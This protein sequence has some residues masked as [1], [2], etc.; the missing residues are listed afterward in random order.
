M[1]NICGMNS[2]VMTESRWPQQHSL[3]KPTTPSLPSAPSP[4]PL[5]WRSRLAA[6]FVG[7]LAVLSPQGAQLEAGWRQASGPCWGEAAWCNPRAS[8]QSDLTAFTSCAPGD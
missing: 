7:S 4:H 5:T 2:L 1:L 3:P 6:A 8:R